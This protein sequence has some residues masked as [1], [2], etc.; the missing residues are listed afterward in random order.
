MVEVGMGVE[1]AGDTG[2]RAPDQVEDV[3]GVIAGVDQPAFTAGVIVEQKAID[4]KG[5]DDK[6]V[7]MDGH[8]RGKGG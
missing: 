3:V 6:M 7:Q 1:D 8:S 5:A 2:A 4:L